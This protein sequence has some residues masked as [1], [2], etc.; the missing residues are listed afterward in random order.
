[1]DCR[2]TQGETGTADYTDFTAKTQKSQRKATTHRR[3]RGGRRGKDVAGWR[4]QKSRRD[5]IIIAKSRKMSFNPE[6][7]KYRVGNEI[8]SPLRG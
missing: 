3:G 2:R 1:M 8:M 5:G 4:S 7:V 6:G